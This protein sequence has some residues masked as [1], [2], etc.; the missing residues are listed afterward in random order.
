M[1][2]HYRRMRYG[3]ALIPLLL[4]AACSGGPAAYGITGPSPVVV[5]SETQVENPGELVDP[6]LTPET[7][8]T[9]FWGY[10]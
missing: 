7:A 2:D 1:P 3:L 8:R 4:L 6:M 5:P 9:R 10:N